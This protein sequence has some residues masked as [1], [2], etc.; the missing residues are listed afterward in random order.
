MGHALTRQYWAKD[1]YEPIVAD[2]G[3]HVD[4]VRGGKKDIVTRA[5]EKVDA[6]LA[7]HTVTRLA[8]EQ[9]TVVEDVLAEA[10]EYYRQNGL[11]DDEEWAPYMAAIETADLP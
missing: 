4:W 7:E 5:E 8:A 9:K 2:W 1:R 11:I 6:I 10:R 3:T